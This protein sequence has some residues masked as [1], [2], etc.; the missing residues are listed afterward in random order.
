V[1]PIVIID[2]YDMPIQQG[3]NNGFYNEIVEFTRNMYSSTFKDN[4]T[5]YKG[6]LTGVL[7][8]SK[9]SIFSGFNNPKTDTVFDERYSEYFGFT[10][11]EVRQMANY[12]D[13]AD[14]YSEICDWYDG[15]K[16][17]ETEIFNPWSVI[18]YFDNECKV[19]PYW[20]NSASNDIIKDLMLF[21]DDIINEK[22]QELLLGKTIET[23]INTN[24]VY[25]NLKTNKDAI[26]SFLLLTG[27][28]KIVNTKLTTTGKN[29]C[30]LSI[31]NME[32]FT[33]YEDEI[34]S[35]LNNGDS[36]NLIESIKEMIKDGKVV[37]LLSSL[38]KLLL[39][40]ASFHDSTGGFHHGLMFALCIIASRNY[41]VTSNRESGYGRYDI[42]MMP[43][44]KSLPGI[45]IEIKTSKKCSPTQLKTLAKTAL[46]Q[47][48]EEK[49]D[50]EMIQN[51]IRTIYKFGIAFSGKHIAIEK[52]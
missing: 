36:T 33:I 7:R 41:N 1:K 8:V 2:E 6:F 46:K 3:Y 17:G 31:P 43:K 13:A 25:P 29:K 38:E 51:N 45:I 22:L 50:T 52:Q 5:I 30:L 47:I 23:I 24:I 40:S 10:H 49:Y 9:E 12:Y 32:I 39:E 11:D 44:N 18:N 48:E 27:Y 21:N 42:M 26:F 20:A 37:N 35:N 19:Y 14:T 16:I 28:L 34:L 15:Y 4:D